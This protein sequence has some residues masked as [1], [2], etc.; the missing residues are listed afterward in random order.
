MTF[1][2]PV[3]LGIDEAHLNKSMRAVYTDIIGRKVLDIQPSR[4]KSDVKA[5]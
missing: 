4:K 3:I 5:F 2:T 1:L